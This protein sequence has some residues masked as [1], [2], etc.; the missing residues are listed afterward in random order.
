MFQ[1]L[2]PEWKINSPAMSKINQEP[3][4][5]LI[6]SYSTPWYKEYESL[7]FECQQ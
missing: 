5:N 7:F 2:S 4:I 1:N 6:D 3:F